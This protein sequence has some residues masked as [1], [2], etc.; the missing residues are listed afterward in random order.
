[1]MQNQRSIQRG[2]ASVPHPSR[3]FKN[4]TNDDRSV[5]FCINQIRSALDDDPQSPRYIETLPRKGYRFIAP[6]APSEDALKSAPESRRFQRLRWLLAGVGSAV[7]AI[8]LLGSNEGGVRD[9]I[10]R[11]PGVKP[12]RPVK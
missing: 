5:N 2:R 4:F 10:L 12:I 6:P 3:V 11:Q 7:A 8:V 1:M 9:R